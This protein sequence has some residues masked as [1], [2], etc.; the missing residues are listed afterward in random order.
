MKQIGPLLDEIGIE[1]F[2]V[3]GRVRL[4]CKR[5]RFAC[6]LDVCGTFGILLLR[7][8]LQLTLSTPLQ[9]A[10]VGA[11]LGALYVMLTNA[12]Y[13]ALAQ[14]E[15]AERDLLRSV[16]VFAAT[17]GDDNARTQKSLQSVVAL[18]EAWQRPDDAAPFR[19]RLQSQR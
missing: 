15:A 10:I 3:Q 14:Y 13:T 8:Y 17:L 18:Y 7:L 1:F 4:S 6:R 12:A 5:Q 9:G 2:G 19:Q 11:V 16:E